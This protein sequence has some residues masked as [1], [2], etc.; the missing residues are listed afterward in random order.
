MAVDV[1][2]DFEGEGEDVRSF[3]GEGLFWLGW[4]WGRR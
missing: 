3:W 1:V 2:A 4:F